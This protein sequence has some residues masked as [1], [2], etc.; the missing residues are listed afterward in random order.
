MSYYLQFVYD[1]MFPRNTPASRHYRLIFLR[2]ANMSFTG[3][4]NGIRLIYLKE[5]PRNFWCLKHTTIL[6]NNACN[7][8]V[9]YWLFISFDLGG[10][11]S[12]TPHWR[13]S[14]KTRCWRR[15]LQ[16][17]TACRF[18]AA[19]QKLWCARTDTARRNWRWNKMGWRHELIHTSRLATWIF[20]SVYSMPRRKPKRWLTLLIHSV[21]AH[22]T[23]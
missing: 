10:H 16:Y 23:A 5:L 8:S 20:V 22:A 13:I 3:W 7:F 14:R 19:M 12:T 2:W 1:D 17:D 15:L 11:A 4:Y 18:R 9:W 6:L 21:I